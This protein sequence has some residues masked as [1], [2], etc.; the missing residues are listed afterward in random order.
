MV[1]YDVLQKCVKEENNE[2]LE[3]FFSRELE[4][5]KSTDYIGSGNLNLRKLDPL[6]LEKESLCNT[7]NTKNVWSMLWILSAP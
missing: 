2:G 4:Y 7:K 3:W 1:F 5:P 6:W